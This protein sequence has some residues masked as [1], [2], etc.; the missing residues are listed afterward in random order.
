MANPSEGSGGSADQFDIGRPDNRRS[1]N[2]HS[3]DVPNVKAAGGSGGSE[4]RDLDGEGLR[5]G[6]RRIEAA[7]PA[8]D[9]AGATPQDPAAP[10]SPGYIMD[11]EAT[12]VKPLPGQGVKR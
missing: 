12:N 3:E 11:E 8:K 6:Y 2:S 7:K 9:L 4:V 1:T 5:S 10:S